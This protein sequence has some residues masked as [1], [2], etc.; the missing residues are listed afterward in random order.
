MVGHSK[1]ISRSTNDEDRRHTPFAVQRPDFLDEW[2]DGLLVG[3]Y[4]QGHLVIADH[5]VGRTRIFVNQQQVRASLKRL[6]VFVCVCVCV[7]VNM[8]FLLISPILH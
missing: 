7:C 3:R 1:V 2:G 5:K 8:S 6:Y 4:Q